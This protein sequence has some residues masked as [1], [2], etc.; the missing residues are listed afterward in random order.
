LWALGETRVST[1]QSEIP[2]E[3]QEVTVDKPESTEDELPTAFAP[4]T[5][6]FENLLDEH[7]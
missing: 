2:A 5:S 6:Q 7:R 1:A 4:A 3:V